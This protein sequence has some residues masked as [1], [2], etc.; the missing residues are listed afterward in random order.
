MTSSVLC[1]F[2]ASLLVIVFAILF[3][4]HLEKW[5]EQKITKKGGFLLSV[6]TNM[7]QIRNVANRKRWA[8]P[9]AAERAMQRSDKKRCLMFRQGTA[10][11]VVA[12]DH[13]TLQPDRNGSVNVRFTRAR[14]PILEPANDGRTMLPIKPLVTQQRSAVVTSSATSTERPS[15]PDVNDPEW[16][17]FTNSVVAMTAIDA[18]HPIERFATLE[19]ARAR[20]D[21]SVT[22]DRYIVGG[23]PTDPTYYVMGIRAAD[24]VVVP[25]SSGTTVYRRKKNQASVQSSPE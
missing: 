4:M 13:L 3:S 16:E 18:T 25:V 15:S 5:R 6:R 21:T 19:E 10:W 22:T 7:N 9:M 20:V 23:S 14:A 24:I 12:G 11:F 2:V 1:V 8:C 17:V